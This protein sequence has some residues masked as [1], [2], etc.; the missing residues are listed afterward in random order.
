MGDQV[1][2]RREFIEHNALTVENLGRLAGKVKPLPIPVFN[3]LCIVAAL[4]M[5]PVGHTIVSLFHGIED[6]WHWAYANLALGF[7]GFVAIWQGV[8]RP[9]L[10]ALCARLF[11]RAPDLRRFL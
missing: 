2:P 5:M 7:A 10:E 11:R 3:L 6:P 8:K 9:E 1:E 4:A